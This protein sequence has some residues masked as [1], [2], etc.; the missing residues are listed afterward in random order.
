MKNICL[1]ISDSDCGFACLKMI[2]SFFNNERSYLY[3][4]TDISK[5]NNLSFYDLKNIALNYG[6]SLNGYTIENYE[7]ISI[8]PMISLVKIDNKYHYVI[9]EKITKKHIYVI[10]PSIGKCIYFV[11][12]YLK[13]STNKYLI[14]ENCQKITF[15][16]KF[17][18]Y[19]NWWIYYLCNFIQIISIFLLSFE[20]KIFTLNI[21]IFGS[22]FL[23]MHVLKKVFIKSCLKKF[24][25][26]YIYPIL[27]ES[28]RNDSFITHKEIDNLYLL[29]KHYFSFFQNKFSISITF[30]FLIFF[31][32]I[33]NIYHTLFLSL[34]MIFNLFYHQIIHHYL[35]IK[36][37]FCNSKSYINKYRSLDNHAYKTSNILQI[38]D[39]I[40]FILIILSNI[41]ICAITSNFTPF[42]YYIIMYNITLNEFHKLLNYNNEKLNLDKYYNFYNALILKIKKN[43]RK[44]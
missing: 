13:I 5:Y 31:L 19:F 39:S 2:I 9:I 11:D 17:N 6:L 8:F 35:D 1:Q 29:K 4:P 43:N 37:F 42:I 34:L 16:L 12:D 7:N 44:K 15:K 24:D 21:L 26:H 3:L 22:I 41:I 38:I 30:S 33:N 25:K 27:E 10:D 40:K 18:I 32:C 20:T 36:P 14:V 28:E 23:L